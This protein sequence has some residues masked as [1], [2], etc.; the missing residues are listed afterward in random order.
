MNSQS[1]FSE[2]NVG[3]S[4][5]VD[6]DSLCPMDDDRASVVLLRILSSTRR[7]IGAAALRK[8]VERCSETELE[9]EK[10]EQEGAINGA[11]RLIDHITKN[12][13]WAINNCLDDMKQKKSDAEGKLESVNADIEALKNPR[14][15]LRIMPRSD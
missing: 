13:E 1:I 11:S 5:D 9:S 4:L 14:E 12:N 6:I 15:R 3:H 7:I 10:T 8:N 2:R